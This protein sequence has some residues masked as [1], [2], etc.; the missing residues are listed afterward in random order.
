MRSLRLRRFM[1]FLN[2]IFPND[3]AEKQILII[4]NKGALESKIKFGNDNLIYV[5]A[6]GEENKLSCHKI[7]AVFV[8]GETTISTVIIRKAVKLGIS[9]FFLKRNLETYA[10]I[11]SKAEGNYL[12][13]EKQYTAKADLIIA[14][15]LVANKLHN[16]QMLLGNKKSVN[17]NTLEA[18]IKKVH[19]AKNDK[20]LLGIEGSATKE[21]FQIFFADIGWRR[22]QPRV[23]LDINNLLLDIGYSL[24]FNYIDSL[25]RLFGFDVYKGYYHKLF[26]KRKSLS[27]DIM[28]P[29]RCIID[30]QLLKSFH[31]KQINEKDFKIK[32]GQYYLG[33]DY[34]AK[35]IKIFL[36]AI[37]DNKMETFN[38]IREFYRFVMSDGEP[39]KFPFFSFN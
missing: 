21:F 8:L 36:T 11:E 30:K 2:M 7:L 25:L 9:I 29:F 32:N 39:E 3:F 31:L 22:R 6:N 27:C 38:F 18:L 26:F 20:E 5:A 23:K 28:E 13:R 10:T 4:E 12:L 34:S 17:F 37:L 1:H 35:Y 14:K 19:Q 24:L 33:W 15:N 16:Q